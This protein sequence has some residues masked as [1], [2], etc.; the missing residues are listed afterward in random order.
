MEEGEGGGGR[1]WRRE[2]VEEGGGKGG[3]REE[4]GGEVEA[5]GRGREAGY[6]RGGK[7]DVNSV[8]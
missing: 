1:G 2:G 5:R 7:S 4:R 8:V 3:G 6:E